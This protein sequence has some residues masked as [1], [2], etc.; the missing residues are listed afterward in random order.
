M[1]SK[2]PRKS[3]AEAGAG[4]R[5][6]DV[7]YA[8]ILEALF[9][10]RLPAGAFVSQSELVNLIG[11]PL[12]PVRDALRMLEGEGILV[13]HPRTG[14]QMLKPGLELTR[15]TYQ[16]RTIIE[17]AAVATFADTAPDDLIDRPEK[18]A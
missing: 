13:I 10:Q 1:A 14:I 12:A 16:Y 8:R 5:L 15:S 4:T 3:A 2:T 7:A 6:S 11:I 9:N 17:S 18:A